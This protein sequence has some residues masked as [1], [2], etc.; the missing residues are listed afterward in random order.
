MEFS[1]C[2]ALNAFYAF[3]YVGERLLQIVVNM[4]HG[5]LFQTFNT[6]AYL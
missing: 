4:K 3:I 5:N 6:K 1:I 2:M